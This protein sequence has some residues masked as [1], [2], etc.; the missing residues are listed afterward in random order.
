MHIALTKFRYFSRSYCTQYDRLLAS[1]WRVVSGDDWRCTIGY[2]SATATL[3]VLCNLYSKTSKRQIFDLVRCSSSVE[4]WPRCGRT[5]R[6][7]LFRWFPPLMDMSTKDAMSWY[8]FLSVIRNHWTRQRCIDNSAVKRAW[9]DFSQKFGVIEN[10]TTN[11]KQDNG[12]DLIPY[13]IAKR[14]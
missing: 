10:S 6:L 12:G 11:N 1:P 9:G 2:F 4:R 13:C 7:W 8:D 14:Y 5:Y 3:L